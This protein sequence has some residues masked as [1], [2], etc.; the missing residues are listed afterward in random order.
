MGKPRGKNLTTRLPKL[1]QAPRPQRHHLR[2]LCVKLLGTQPIIFLNLLISKLWFMKRSLSQ[3]SLRSKLPYWDQ[4]RNSKCCAQITLVP[5]VITM[6]NI[7]IFSLIS[8][9][10]VIA[11][12]IFA[13]TRPLI[14]DQLLLYPLIMVPLVNQNRGI[15]VPPSW[16]LPPMSRWQT[17]RAISLTY[18]PPWVPNRKTIM[19]FMCALLSNLFRHNPRSQH[20]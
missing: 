15:L 7:P 10:F 18:R 5:C 17:P 3:M 8:M 4:P 20:S 14:V 12:R 6:V 19:R 13:N 1:L 11:L 9:N 16:S 2:A